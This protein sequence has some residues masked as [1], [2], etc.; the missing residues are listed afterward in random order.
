MLLAVPLLK[1]GLASLE[2]TLRR[3]P[4]GIYIN[5]TNGNFSNNLYASHFTLDEGDGTITLSLDLD[6]NLRTRFKTGNDYLDVVELAEHQDELRSLQINNERVNKGIAEALV[7]SPI[8]TMKLILHIG[9]YGSF[10]YLVNPE[11]R[12]TGLVFG[13]VASNESD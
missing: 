8:A 4:A 13:V 2:K 7:R 6:A 1:K 12:R 11:V 3:T 5:F 10:Q 9:Q